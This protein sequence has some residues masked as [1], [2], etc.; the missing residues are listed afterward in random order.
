MVGIE[1]LSNQQVCFRPMGLSLH[2]MNA[3]S[4]SSN[5]SLSSHHT[6]QIESPTIAALSWINSKPPLLEVLKGPDQPLGK[7]VP[8]ALVALL[9]SSPFQVL[10]NEFR[11]NPCNHSLF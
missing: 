4:A 2:P 9:L 11:P 5:Q 1:A 7:I 3:S 8:K 10:Q 6:K